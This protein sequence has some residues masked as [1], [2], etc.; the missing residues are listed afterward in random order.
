LHQHQDIQMQ[1]GTFEFLE[2][3]VRYNG[4]IDVIF[5]LKVDNRL[6]RFLF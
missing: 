1:E 3:D 4:F 6:F 5:L 2:I